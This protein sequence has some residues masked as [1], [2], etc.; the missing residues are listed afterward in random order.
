M[1]I[2]HKLQIGNTYSNYYYCCNK[3]AHTF[4]TFECA[5]RVGT[6]VLV[7]YGCNDNDSWFILNGEY[8]HRVAAAHYNI[9]VV[10]NVS[11]ALPIAVFV[12]RT[13]VTR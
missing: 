5:V 3:R 2:A 8:H 4:R 6:E 1:L 7:L 10:N 9:T 13:V 12:F 11:T